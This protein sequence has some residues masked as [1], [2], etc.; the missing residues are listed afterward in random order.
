MNVQQVLF[1]ENGRLRSG[2]RF[3]I[4]LLAFVVAGGMIRGAVIA[5]LSAPP[6]GFGRQ[7]VIFLIGTSAVSLAAVVGF[8]WLCGKYLENL[9]FRALGASF[10]RTWSRDLLWGLAIGGASLL[11]AA[12]LGF[13]FGGLR[14]GFNEN[15]GAA[16]IGLTLGVSFLIF[17]VA[18]MFEE[19]FFR[20]YM[21]QTFLRSD[22]AWLAVIITSLMFAAAHNQNPSANYISFFNTFLG[23]LWLAV[24]YLK[25]RTLWLPLGVHLSWNWMQGAVMGINVSGLK[26]LTTAPLLAAADTGPAWLT[27]GSYGIEGGLLGTVSLIAST[28]VIWYLPW[29]GPTPEMLALTSPAK[30]T[31]TNDYEIENRR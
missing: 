13:V 3:L 15:Y 31:A 2:W 9:P 4:F 23:G 29:I 25:T 14:F 22:L 8:G 21:L 19:A 24:A 1:D 28:V 18:A 26:E 10:V 17:T 7:S 16:A 6:I 5:F 12:L 30:Q 11:F 27:G 20:G